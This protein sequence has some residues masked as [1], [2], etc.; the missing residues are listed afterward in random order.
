M[1]RA[2]AFL[3]QSK[4]REK[5]LRLSQLTLALLAAIER[6]EGNPY[7]L[8]G[9]RYGQPLVNLHKPWTRLCQQ[10]GLPQV[11][12]HD[13]RHTYASLG[14]SMGL[15]LPIVRAVLG[16]QHTAT[17]QRCAHLA[18]DPVQEGAERIG[19]AVARALRG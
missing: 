8:P 17:T 14:V 13:L 12:P 10:A 2:R 5:W 3:L 11:R 9:Q 6:Q 7:V 18:H 4:T 15:S 16:H 1:E 19:E